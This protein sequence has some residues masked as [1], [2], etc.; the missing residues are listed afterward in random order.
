MEGKAAQEHIAEL[1][2]QEPPRSHVLR[3]FLNPIHQSPIAV[4][5]KGSSECFLRERIK[6]FQ[7]QESHVITTQSLSFSF[8]FEENLAAAKQNARDVTAS[9]TRIRQYALEPSCREFIKSRGRSGMTEKT[10]GRHHNERFAPP[11]QDLPPQTVKELYGRCRLNDLD[12]IVD[13]QF[14][15]SF[16]PGAG[17]FGS[18]AFQPVRKQERNSTQASPFFFSGGDK[19]VDDHLCDV[20]EIPEL[21]LPKNEPVRRVETVA[22]FKTEHARF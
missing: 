20:P 21:R 10:F 17:M 5:D 9:C 6:L 12:V 2:F 19:L 14:E 13:S 8:E 3:L 7:T 4:R 18:L 11:S 16:Q 22:I 15:K 1:Y